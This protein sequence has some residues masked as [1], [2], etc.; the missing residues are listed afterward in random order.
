MYDIICKL[1]YLFRILF[2]NLFRCVCLFLLWV[3]LFYFYPSQ[4][5]SWMKNANT[6]HDSGLIYTRY[7]YIVLW[8][9]QMAIN[10]AWP[11]G[12]LFHL[13]NYIITTTCRARVNK[14]QRC[15]G[16]LWDNKLHT[17]PVTVIYRIKYDSK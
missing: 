4:T 16:S 2:C 3:D 14:N 7:K 11:I 8:W 9:P 1:K 6:T 10:H 12:I 15:I 5:L 13:H 17:L